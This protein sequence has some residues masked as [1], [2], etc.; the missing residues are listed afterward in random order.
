MSKRKY[1]KVQGWWVYSIQ[2][3]SNGKYYIGVSRCKECCQRWHKSAYESSSLQPYLNEFDSMIKTVLVDNLTKEQ[4]YQYED[5]I[6]RALKMND[7]CIN[8]QRSGLITS[9][10]NTYMKELKKNKPERREQA[11]QLCK[12]WYENNKE[13]ARE[14]NKQYYENNKEKRIEYHKQWKENNP[15]YYKQYHKRK[16]LKKQQQ[17]SVH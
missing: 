16:K 6:I 10:I 4:A 13:K 17:T 1:P 7:L 8:K 3:K 12:Q 2:I 15:D 14:Y 5:N 11:K 9:D